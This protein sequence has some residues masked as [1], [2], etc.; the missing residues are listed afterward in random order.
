MWSGFDPQMR[1]EL[2]NVR[3]MVGLTHQAPTREWPLFFEAEH[4]ALLIVREWPDGSV[5]AYLTSDIPG[6]SQHGGKY[7]G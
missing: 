7:S 2:Q 4:D 1:R 5:T 6:S 3:Q